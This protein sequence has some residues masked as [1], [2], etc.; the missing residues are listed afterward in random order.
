MPTGTEEDG[1]SYLTMATKQVTYTVFDALP[2]S[3]S[4]GTVL[5]FHELQH[6]M[7]TPIPH[8]HTQHVTRN[9]RRARV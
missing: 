1:V 9:T 2:C 8:T 3:K 6:A 7:L 5:L 4:G